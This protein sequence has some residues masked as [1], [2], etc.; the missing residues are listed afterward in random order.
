VTDELPSWLDGLSI[1][2]VRAY[3]R[4]W[5]VVVERGHVTIAEGV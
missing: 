2:G 5:T 1:E 4:T 3:G